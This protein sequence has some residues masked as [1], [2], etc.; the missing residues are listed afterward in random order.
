MSGSTN[1]SDI[2]SR[3]KLEEELYS[4][5]ESLNDTYYDH[6]K[7]SQQDAL[8]SE[9]KAYEDTMTK[10]VEGMRTSL[11]QA[12]LDMD[13][14]LGNVTTMVTLNAGAILTEYQNTG[15]ELDP[16]LTTPWVNAKNA[17]GDYSEDALD[18]MNKWTQGGFFTTFPNAVGNSL[19]SPWGVGTKAVDAF[20]ISVENAM[21]DVVEQ[22]ESNISIAKGNLDSLYKQIIETEERAANITVDPP[23]NPD[24]PKETEQKGTLDLKKQRTGVVDAGANGV[25]IVIQKK[26]VSGRTETIGG[27]KYLRAQDGYYYDFD[28]VK[29][30]GDVYTI[31]PGTKRWKKKT[32]STKTSV[33]STS[34]KSQMLMYAKGTTGTTRDQWAITDEPKFGDELVLIPGKDGNL[35]FMRKGTGVVPADMTQKLFELAQIPTSDLMNKNLTAIVPNITKNDFKNEFNF[36]SLVHVDTVDSDTLP[37]LEKMVDKKID[38]FSRA[39]NYSLKKF[40]R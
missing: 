23:K 6:A 33:S 1:K 4:A 5:R 25:S 3:R 19:S 21:E 20:T 35:S 2:A 30:G 17:V 26:D 29:K 15:V 7:Q 40:A 14:F 34:N 28:S 24:P 11:E 12:T 27:Y 38:D 31:V 9:A 39:L 22:I 8:D 18:L 16:A 32:G 37:K 10:M 13:T 36:E